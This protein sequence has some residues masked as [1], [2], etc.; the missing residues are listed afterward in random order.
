M[1]DIHYHLI[2][3]AIAGGLVLVG[4]LSTILTGNMTTEQIVTG[5]LLGILAGIGVFLTKFGEWFKTKDKCNK[6][7]SFI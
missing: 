1:K 3:S 4:S 5:V 2:N 6:L 7:F